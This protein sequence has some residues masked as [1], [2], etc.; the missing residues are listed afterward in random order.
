MVDGFS[1]QKPEIHV[2][3]ILNL[4]F[5]GIGKDVLTGISCRLAGSSAGG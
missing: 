3:L 2:I 1:L 5:G 4:V